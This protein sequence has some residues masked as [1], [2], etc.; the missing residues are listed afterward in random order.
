MITETLS[1]LTE[2]TKGVLEPV[3]KLNQ[4]A[5]AAI[6][7]LATHQ[8]NSLKTYTELGVSQLKAVAEVRD[9]EGLQNLVSKQTDVLREVGD[10]LMS[11]F[12][13][14]SQMGVNFISHS[15]KVGPESV[16][17]A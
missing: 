2:P 15:T 8:I 11:D 4:Q 6:E 9:V 5:I 13:A 14:I 17:A 3:H 7:K 16:K 1:A 10:R 12:K